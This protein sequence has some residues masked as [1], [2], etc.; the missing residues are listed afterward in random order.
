MR[1]H[2][3]SADA[4]SGDALFKLVTEDIQWSQA[5]FLVVIIALC[6]DNGGD[7]RKMRRLVLALMPWLVVIVC[8][9]HQIN[10]IVGD[11]LALR[12]DFLT[13][14]PKALLVIKWMNNHSRALGIFRREQLNSYKLITRSYPSSFL[15][16]LDGQPITSP[17]PDFWPLKYRLRQAG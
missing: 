16:S 6:S 5:M 1:T 4:K 14:V 2:D 3:V 9:A 11:Y 8:W 7:A 17:S 10:L 13:C 12:T 15:S